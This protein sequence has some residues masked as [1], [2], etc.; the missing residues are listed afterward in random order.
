MTAIE[1]LG[2]SGND[3]CIKLYEYLKKRSQ[4]TE[5]YARSLQKLNK[6]YHQP[7]SPDSLCLFEQIIGETEKCAECNF[8]VSKE[9]QDV[10]M[11]N[12]KILAREHERQRRGVN[13]DIIHFVYL[14]G[15]E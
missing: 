5:D 10:T 6:S 1:E 9:V 13:Q 12:L 7:T 3:A 4:L 11:N 2:Q 8:E 15:I 14:L